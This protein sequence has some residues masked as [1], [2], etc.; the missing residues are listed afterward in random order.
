MS[1]ADLTNKVALNDAFRISFLGCRPLSYVEE[2]CEA[3]TTLVA[4]G[5]TYRHFAVDD[6][7]D[8]LYFCDVKKTGEA[9]LACFSSNRGKVDNDFDGSVL[10]GRV[11]L[12]QKL[13]FLL[14]GFFALSLQK[15]LGSSTTCWAL[16]WQAHLSLTGKR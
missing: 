13:L 3:K 15:Y 16:E 7:R 14:D 9:G 5:L 8:I 12:R 2:T 10:F 1:A 4:Q 11:L 6:V